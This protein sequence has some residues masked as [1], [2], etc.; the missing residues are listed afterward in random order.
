MKLTIFILVL[1]IGSLNM[2]AQQSNNLIGEY[3]LQ[4]VREIASGFKLNTDSSFDFFFSYGALD[5]SGKGTWHT[6]GNRITFNSSAVKEKDFIL[7][8]SKNDSNERVMV[9]IVDSNPILRSSVYVI[10]KAGENVQE[11]VTNSNGEISF[12]KQEIDSIKMV[13]EFCP[14]KKFGFTNVNKQHNRFEFG[15]EKEIMEVFFHQLVLTLTE[16]GMEGT[17]PLLRDGIYKFRKN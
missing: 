13:L 10:I 6:E 17:H 5:R 11:G 7:L 2:N 12:T 3:Y 4:G 14:E 15:I 8:S 9:K 16:E 1:S